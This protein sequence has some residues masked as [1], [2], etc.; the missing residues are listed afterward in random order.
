[1]SGEGGEKGAKDFLRDTFFT[2]FEE[3][4]KSKLKEAGGAAMERNKAVA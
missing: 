4:R 2:S 1:M 3:Q